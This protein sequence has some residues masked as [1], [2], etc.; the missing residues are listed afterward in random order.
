MV[1]FI[2]T[3]LVTAILVLS[4]VLMAIPGFFART[5]RVNKFYRVSGL[6]ILSATLVIILIVIFRNY[7]N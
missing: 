6:F 7:G 4:F 3:F 5:E 1:D 2:L